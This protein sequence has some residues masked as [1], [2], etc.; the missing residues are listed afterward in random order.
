MV[1]IKNCARIHKDVTITS[2]NEIFFTLGEIAERYEDRSED[3]V[4]GVTT[5][6]GQINIRP[7]YQRAFIRETDKTWRSRLIDSVLNGRPI[8]NF[9]FAGKDKKG[10]YDVLDGQQRLMTLCS[11][12][13]NGR[14]G[15]ID[16]EHDGKIESAPFNKFPPK[17]Q[18][19]IKNYKIPVY[20]CYGEEDG[21]LNW[22]TTINQPHSELTKQEIR[23][24]VYCGTFVESAKQLFS[25]TKATSNPTSEFL[26]KSSPYYYKNFSYDLKPERQDF[27]EKV[28]DWVSMPMSD[29]NPKR[30]NETEDER[31]E[32]ISNY[33]AIHR[34]DANA[35]SL[36]IGYKKI[37]D[38][39]YNTFHKEIIE[40]KGIRGC[41]WG[42]LYALFSDKT[43][44]L[45]KI[46]HEIEEL[47]ANDSIA[48][49]R[50]V[51]K[52]VLAGKQA[53][54]EDENRRY[55]LLNVKGLTAS[56]R[57]KLY[58]MQNGIDPIDG[59]V[60]SIENMQAHHIKP[61]YGG[62]ETKIANM[63]LL[64]AENH[65]K[66]HYEGICTAEEL[67]KKRDDLIKSNGY[68]ENQS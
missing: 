21:M 54:D 6:N 25:K 15:T 53:N 1:N 56:E 31:D 23:N 32:R 48:F 40:Q 29:Y 19:A 35:D 17:W 3:N 66:Y 58:K 4:G 37:V 68:K 14:Q 27:L 44:D 33:M 11:V 57:T 16:I 7:K 34:N 43:F 64:S 12:I 10:Y 49:T 9:Y 59:K 63:V 52:Y 47:L 26:S 45:D 67:K 62:G 41:N 20:V 46:N 42:E 36:V 51:P 8:G 55:K 5:M 61:I 18:D 38:W 39:A 22:F 65:R 13:N 24:A 2:S 50:N 30:K 28:I 60:Y